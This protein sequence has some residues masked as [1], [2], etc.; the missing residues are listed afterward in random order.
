MKTLEQM[1]GA[2][3][4]QQTLAD[5]VRHENFLEYAYPDP[6]SKLGK[7]DPLF[8]KYG[9]GKKPATVI[10]AQY[11]FK[12][13]DGRPWTVGVGYTR[14]VTPESR[15][16]KEQALQKLSGELYVHLPVIDKLIPQWESF[17]DVV[18]TVLANL[19]FN[20]GNRLTQF[21]TSLELLRQRRFPQAA[22]NLRKTLWAKQTKTR[23]DELTKRLET[24]VVEKRYLIAGFPLPA[25]FSDVISEVR[26]T[27]EFK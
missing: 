21:K 10:L 27:E 12:E 14:G 18:K 16:S 15:M 7:A 6:L 1:K 22:A 26:S 17:P 19:A 4:F 2:W 11:G 20:M 5:L 8:K 9:W 23:A 24:G 13:A 3:W 25:D